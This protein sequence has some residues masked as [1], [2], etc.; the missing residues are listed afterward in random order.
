M[1]THAINLDAPDI[2]VETTT[3]DFESLLS[4][5]PWDGIDVAVSDLMLGAISGQDILRY[6]REHHPH[7]RRIAMTAALVSAAEVT[8]LADQV[9]VKPFPSGDLIEAIR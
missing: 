6:L 5:D 3:S 1:L 4:P 8:G 2:Q 9:L 7:I